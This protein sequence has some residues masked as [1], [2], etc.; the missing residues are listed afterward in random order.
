MQQWSKINLLRIL[1]ILWLSVSRR[2]FPSVLFRLSAVSFIFQSVWVHIIISVTLLQKLKESRC[3]FNATAIIFTTVKWKVKCSRTAF[4][5]ECFENDSSYFSTHWLG[6]A[7]QTCNSQSL[8]RVSHTLI[9]ISFSES[10]FCLSA[11]LRF[12]LSSSL[13]FLFSSSLWRFFSSSLLRRS[14][15]FSSLIL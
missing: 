3:R 4:I 9:L 15:L 7:D 12:R 8:T 10:F 1:R 5:T 6:T 14:S 11:S 2:L 13:R